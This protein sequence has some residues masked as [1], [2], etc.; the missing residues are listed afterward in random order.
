MLRP[1][2]CRSV[3]ISLPASAR[4]VLVGEGEVAHPVGDQAADGADVFL[5]LHIGDDGIAA[6]YELRA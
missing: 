4:D 5:P 2:P 3:K 1:S 6:A